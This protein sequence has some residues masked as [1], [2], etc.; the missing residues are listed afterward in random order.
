MVLN[1][2]VHIRF[3]IGHIDVVGESAAT[4]SSVSQLQFNESPSVYIM[5][6][7]DALNGTMHFMIN[8]VSAK[9]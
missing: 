7:L 9:W 1:L 5:A 4:G 6:G 2:K 3:V 8:L